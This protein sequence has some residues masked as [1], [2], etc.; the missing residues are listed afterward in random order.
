MFAKISV[1]IS[2][3]VLG[4]VRGILGASPGLRLRAFDLPKRTIGFMTYVLVKKLE[5]VSFRF[6]VL[7]KVS[8]ALL[9]AFVQERNAVG[10]GR[11]NSR[12]RHFTNTNFC[13]S[14]ASLGAR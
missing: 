2:F 6:W 14:Q 1:H 8:S 3:R 5:R 10:K 13:Q 9:R 12:I 7:S 11:N 4:S